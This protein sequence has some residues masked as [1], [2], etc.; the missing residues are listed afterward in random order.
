MILCVLGP[1]QFAPKM[2]QSWRWLEQTPAAGWVGFLCPCSCWHKT[3]CVFWNRCCILLTS[4]LKIL[5][6]LGHLQCWESSGDLGTLHQVCAQDLLISFILS[7]MPE[8]LSSIS[9]I[10]LVILISVV[11]LLFLKFSISK[12]ASMS[13]FLYCFFFIFRS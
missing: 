13:C 1:A 11:S 8:I 9:C 6:V 10:L 7:F 2:A 4:Y 3:L 12:I 5:G